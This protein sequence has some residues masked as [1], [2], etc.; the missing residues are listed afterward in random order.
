MFS[1]LRHFSSGTLKSRG[2]EGGVRATLLPEVAPASVPN[3]SL[4]CP[5][6]FVAIVRSLPECYLGPS[7]IAYT[8]LFSN[9]ALRARVNIALL[10][11]GLGPVCPLVVEGGRQVRWCDQGPMGMM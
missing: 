8:R 4:K 1:G 10:A 2:P 7:G 5:A 9:R 3:V 11:C 6:N